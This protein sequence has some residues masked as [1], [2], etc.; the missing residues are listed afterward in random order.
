M[1][2]E[3]SNYRTRCLWC[4][5]LLLLWASSVRASDEWVL[6]TADF[7]SERVWLRE[8][9]DQAVTITGADGTARTVDFDR[10]L[11]L[12]R[13]APTKP[14]SGRFLLVLDG[15]ERIAGEPKGLQGEILLWSNPSM[16]EIRIPLMR[17]TSM[18]RVSRPNVPDERRAADDVITLV[19]GDTVRGIIAVI[20]ED[21]I[22]I[23]ASGGDSIDVPLDSI[24]AV[25]FAPVAATQ[26]PIEPQGRSFR[27]QLGDG[28]NL[29][30]P[31]LHS[32]GQQLALELLDG[33]SRA[34]PMAS[35]NSIEQLNGP[36][37][38]L[39]SRRPVENVQTPFLDMSAPARMNQ[40]V[41]GAAIRFGDRT[42]ARGIG[43]HSFSR[44]AWRID[45]GYEAFRT[46]YAID[47]Q[48]PYADVV[49]RIKLDQRVVHEQK[50]LRA[51][52]LSPLIVV[53]T[54]GAR[55]IAL[56]VDYGESYDVQ[57]RVN[58]IE[59]ALLK[60]K[61]QPPAPA[62]MPATQPATQPSNPAQ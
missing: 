3:I 58:W 52:T 32:Q 38:W 62:T 19:N 25:A 51:G 47:G 33:S 53:D 2:F 28:T 27:V 41:T 21:A 37:V 10:M 13:I 54:G 50:D 26:T 20:R 45:A 36:V 34:L 8:I 59:P 61:P 49:I 30:V 14:P 15:L 57:D 6:T 12:D 44:L 29:V 40:S 5:G 24:A 18:H 16:G 42:F 31:S 60:H 4:L 35:I 7:R 56:E 43:V 9:S 48:L 1:R 39:S 22:G 55:T 11:Q 23:Q 46:Q 17:V